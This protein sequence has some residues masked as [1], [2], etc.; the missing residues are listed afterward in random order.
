MSDLFKHDLENLGEIRY[1]NRRYRLA[2]FY[3]KYSGIKKERKIDGW[4]GN[5]LYDLSSHS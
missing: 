2:I 4:N 1:K 5:T 3:S